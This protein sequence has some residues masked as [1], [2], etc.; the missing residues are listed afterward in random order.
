MHDPQV[1][2]RSSP[3]GAG[4]GG[5]GLADGEAP[6]SL[7]AALREVPPPPSLPY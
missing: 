2:A 1:T 7:F 6:P 4:A 5:A 3:R